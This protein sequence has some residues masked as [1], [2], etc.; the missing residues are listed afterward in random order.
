MLEWWYIPYF[1]R[2]QN[3]SVFREAMFN[4]FE[5]IL[6]LLLYH[7]LWLI[8]CKSALQQKKLGLRRDL[9]MIHS[10]TTTFLPLL[11]LRLSGKFLHSHN[12]NTSVHHAHPLIN[13]IGICLM[14]AY[15]DLFGL[16]FIILILS[17]APKCFL[18]GI[19]LLLLVFQKAKEAVHHFTLS[20]LQLWH[21]STVYSPSRRFSLVHFI[22]CYCCFLAFL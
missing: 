9:L 16:L 14:F 19:L 15:A 6:P 18:T 12:A 4:I 1:D 20:V 11:C 13:V 8:N 10:H 21:R 17:C 7:R 3:L 2:K 5:D 22:C